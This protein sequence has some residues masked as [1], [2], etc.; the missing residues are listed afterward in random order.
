[1]VGW[2]L[3]DLQPDTTFVVMSDHGFA[4]F[5][6]GANLNTWLEQQGYLQ[7]T[8]PSRRDSYEWLEGID[9]SRTRA[10]AIGLNSLYLN[11]R[12]RERSGIVPPEERAA[13]AREIA[14][15]LAGWQDPQS[16]AAV[17]TQPLVREDIY[18]GSHVED[19]PDIIVGYGHGFRASWDTTTGKIPAE[20]IVDNDAEWSGDHCMD[21]RLVPGVLL[22]NRPL[23][24]GEADL[25]DLPVSILSYF[26]IRPPSQMTGRPVF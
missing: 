11:V 13:L 20:L 22:A 4:P 7:L 14:A 18:R 12:G 25:R 8:D 5:R 17:V 26:G 3:A 21:A 15:K 9:W 16:D 1:M 2:V 23:Q 10:F 6:R 24:A 19:A